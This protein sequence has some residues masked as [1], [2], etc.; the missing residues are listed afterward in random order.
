MTCYIIHR[1]LISILLFSIAH[2][3]P[4]LSQIGFVMR[5]MKQ[6]NNIFSFFSRALKVI[7]C[8]G[9]SDLQVISV[10]NLKLTE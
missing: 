9:S 10:L 6:I 7:E 1:K 3:K 5:F 2:I 8:G 4:T